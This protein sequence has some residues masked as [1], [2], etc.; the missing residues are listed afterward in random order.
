MFQYHIYFQI[1]DRVVG[2]RVLN[3]G[4]IDVTRKSAWRFKPQHVLNMPPST[5]HF[6]FCL[7][8]FMLQK[9]SKIW[10]HYIF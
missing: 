6:L 8:R 2:N 5:L 1:G 3:V 9:L 4:N 10:S 7:K